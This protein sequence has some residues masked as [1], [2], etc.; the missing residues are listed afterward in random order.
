MTSIPKTKIRNFGIDGSMRSTSV[1]PNSSSSGKLGGGG[2]ICSTSL[3]FRKPIACS[4]C[5]NT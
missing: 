2:S 4:T 5:Q 1:K 3:T